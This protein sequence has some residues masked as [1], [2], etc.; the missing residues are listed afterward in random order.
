MRKRPSTLMSQKATSPLTQARVTRKGMGR[1]RGALR[2]SSTTTETP[3]L[4]HRGMTTTKTLCRKRKQL[5]RTTLLIILASLIIRM[6]TYY[7]FHLENPL[8]LMEKIILSGVIKCIVI[9]YLSIQV[10]ILSILDYKHLY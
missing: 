3:P 7:L 6:L 4:L 8:T 1:R 2:R 9:Y 5:I 10:L